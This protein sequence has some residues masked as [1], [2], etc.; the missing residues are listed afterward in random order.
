M[1][2]HVAQAHVERVMAEAGMHGARIIMAGS[3]GAF[4]RPIRTGTDFGGGVRGVAGPGRGRGRNAGTPGRRPG[5][6]GEH[7]LR[8]RFRQGRG[9]PG[10]ARPDR[11][12]PRDAGRVRAH[13]DPGPLHGLGRGGGPLRVPRRP[14]ASLRQAWPAG[15]GHEPHGQPLPRRGRHHR[16]AEVDGAAGRAPR[17]REAGGGPAQAMDHRAPAQRRDRV[18]PVG[19]RAPAGRERSRGPAARRRI[20]W[21]PRGGSA[22]SPTCGAE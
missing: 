11:V 1:R 21:P 10:P 17:G 14:G 7:V 2:K 12:R 22:A 13:R 6:G 18:R 5:H 8:A 9:Q 19:R 4:D 20:S 3:Q 15:G 16:A